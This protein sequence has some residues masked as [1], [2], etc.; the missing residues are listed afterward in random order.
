MSI[1]V[2]SDLHLSTLEE[3]NK[4]MEVFGSRW[5]CYM[6][7]IKANWTRLV[8]EK[9]TVVVPGDIS[10]ALSLGEAISDMR[11]IDALPGKKLLGK[12]NHDFWWTTLTKHKKT[13]AENGITTIDF[14][15]NNATVCENYILAGTR[16]WY[17]DED[18][19]GAHEGVDY[20]KLINR[21]ALRLE[22]SLKEATR[23]KSAE[24]NKDKEILVFLHFP[25]VWNGKRC[26]QIISVLVKYGIKRVYFGHIHGS[27]TVPQSF[28]ADG[29]EYYLVS[30]DYLGF[31]PKI[32]K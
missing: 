22:L 7:R 29:I 16:G 17:Q 9:D 20:L 32:I 15:S 8:T 28:V 10:W 4:S 31:I 12:G 5:D 2:I 1:Y 13:F 25:P 23:L 19:K 27:Y 14:L 24:E 30:A 21:E 26:E 18:A 3:T 6:Q 11:F